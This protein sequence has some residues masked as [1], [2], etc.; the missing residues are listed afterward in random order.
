M[1]K[2]VVAFVAV[3]TL[4]SHSAL[5]QKSYPMLMS[6]S[7]AAVQVGQT[8]EH[9]VES[10]YSMFGANQ[11]LIS[12]E[13][14][15]GEVVTPM[16]LG[17]DGKEPALTQIKLK[18]TVAAEA[19]TGVRDFRIIGPTGPSTVG[20]IVITRDPVIVEDPKNDTQE[21]AQA[22]VAP[23]TICGCVEK[24]EDVDFY[25]FTVE[26]PA[27]LTFHCLAM[28][29]K[30]EFM[31]CRHMLTPSSQFA[32]RRPDQLWPPMTTHLPQIRFCLTRSSRAN[33]C[34]RFATCVI[35]ETSTGTM[36]L[37]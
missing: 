34:W 23:G 16:E 5:A 29:L 4:V 19:M 20:Q 10:R 26:Q 32:V 6:L 2:S 15:T 21:T 24:A 35:R 36:S 17:K 22:V 14:V 3:T 9:T 8:S 7:P 1:W 12:G 33:T 13:G 25:R 18:F 27:S 11:V 31:T 30:I 28:H 37:K